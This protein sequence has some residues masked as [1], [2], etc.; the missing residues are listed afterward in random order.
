M[1]ES[2]HGFRRVDAA[3]DAQYFVKFLDEIARS[4]SVQE[5]RR[6]IL[7]KMKIGVGEHVLDLGCGLGDQTISMARL[8]GPS[9]SAVGLDSSVA[10]VEEAT[11]RRSKLE[12]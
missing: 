6:V 1:E 5:C 9:G 3:S 11:R 4:A 2:V 8:A 7:E 12:R 10:M